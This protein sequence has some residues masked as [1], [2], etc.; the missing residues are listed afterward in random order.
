MF[1]KKMISDM[2]KITE[3]GGENVR[4]GFLDY[5]DFRVLLGHVEGEDVKDITEFLY[6]SGWRSGE[7]KNLRWSW[8]NA[9]NTMV[10]LPA[11]FAKSKE[12]RLLPLIGGLAAVI[13][14]RM[15]LRRVGVPWVFHRNGRQMKTFRRAF[16]K[17]A[18]AFLN[19]LDKDAREKYPAMLVPHD[20]RRS[21]VRNFR[22]SGLSLDE[23]M[24]L[25]GYKTAH[26]YHR[27]SIQSPTDRQKSMAKWPSI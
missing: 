21:A 26:V 15:R 13:E 16:N 5:D 1:D 8:I 27:Y 18:A 4:K 3:L 14:R 12:P 22:L 19:G 17:A 23:G 2:P 10:E 7:A 6:L 9:E 25:S 11:E 24:A 20:L